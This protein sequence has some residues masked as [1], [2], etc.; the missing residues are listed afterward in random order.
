M[1]T[2]RIGCVA[3]IAAAC[4]L[5]FSPPARA[6]VRNIRPTQALPNPTS[7]SYPYFGIGVAI[8]GPYII[9]LASAPGETSNTIAALLYGRSLSSG[10]WV[11][12]K[13]LM[14]RTGTFS[15]TDV[16]M[17]SG[18]AAVQ[19]GGQVTLFEHV[20]GDYV[21][22]RVAA[23]IV[24]PG[25]VA[26]SSG[27]LLVGGNGCDYDGVVYEKG[28]NGT[29][30]ITGRLDDD[31]GECDDF[32]MTVELNYNYALLRSQYGA[33][34]SAWRRTGPAIDW[35]PA[36]TLAPPPG[37]N[38]SDQP[39]ALQGATAVANNGY[40]YLRNGTS[41]WVL[42]DRA[43]SVDN[44]NS[45][46]ITFE[47]IYR[48]GVLLA[49]E[50]GVLWPF[51]RVYLETTPGQFEHVA[52][53]ATSQIAW[54]MDVS[55]RTAVSVVRDAEGL[56]WDVEVFALPEMLRAPAPVVNDFEDRDASDF[57]TRSGLFQ[58]AT[59][60]TNDVYA[61]GDSSAFAVALATQSD[62]TDYQR[63]QATI[64]PTYDRSDAWAGLVARY[65]DT[66]NYYFAALRANG[67]FGVYKRVNGVN[68]LL[69]AGTA[70]AATPRR[71]VFTV[72]GNQIFLGINDEL[73]PIGTDN[74]LPRG[75]A[76]I[77][78]WHARA[79]FDDVYITGTTDYGLFF[80]EWGPNG[81]QYDVDLTT[82]GG[83]W[84][85]AFDSEESYSQGLKQLDTT[86]DARAY[87]GTPVANQDITARVRLDG[88]G[89]S[90][91]G[92]WF[93]LLARYVDPRNH[94]YVTARS[95][96]QIQI[97]K[98]VNGVI[99]VLASASFTPVAGQVNDLRFR[100]IG[101]QLQLFVNGELK[102]SAHAGDIASGQ[103]GLATYRTAAT[104]EM[105][106]V[107]QP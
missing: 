91:Q 89:T 64:V 15:R 50:T 40:A 67:A 86:G 85:V 104:W 17:K 1:N 107:S 71:A 26:I 23:P 87:T 78:T 6:E 74:S 88:F 22:A 48:D 81:S 101:D 84:E 19:I 2:F 73:Y 3:L 83:Q 69:R 25:G 96:G 32:G 82:A 92:A 37:V 5:A 21:P 70:N 97:R 79:D 77:A 38:L 24:H 9:V 12:R 30:G 33:V 75:R 31:T 57:E 16:K 28:S 56:R 4:L 76:G 51:P 13:T 8:D 66:R 39:F 46:R 34:A 58:L 47:T 18:I 53:L 105:L 98:I 20:N 80:R 49:S 11:Y 35:V 100:V 7:P 55:G 29:W 68:T 14:T 62:W 44:D 94:Y 99:T 42:Q 103:Y 10:K 102:A 95:T 106:S 41:S 90:S 54:E 27:R 63:I 36:G 59:R 43:T 45:D 65:V 60:G 93:G 61:Q 52:S 72:E